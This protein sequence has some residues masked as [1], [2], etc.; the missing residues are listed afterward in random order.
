M[1]ALV[2]TAGWIWLP[3]SMA[4]AHASLYR[5]QVHS[6]GTLWVTLIMKVSTTFSSSLLPNCSPY[7]ATI[8]RLNINTK[9]L[10]Y[11]HRCWA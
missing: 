4:G 1:C 6:E 10:I 3:R 2:R 9:F 7:L 5:C 8:T 11:W